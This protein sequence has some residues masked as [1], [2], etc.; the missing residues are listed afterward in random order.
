MDNLRAAASITEHTEMSASDD[1]SGF[2]AGGNTSCAECFECSP[3]KE[4]PFEDSSE[5]CC[6]A[7]DTADVEWVRCIVCNKEWHLYC[8]RNLEGLEQP[9][10]VLRSL[11]KIWLMCHTCTNAYIQ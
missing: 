4:D 9:I 2:S 11:V 10:N 5:W 8:Y 6:Y 7:I 1:E 3:G